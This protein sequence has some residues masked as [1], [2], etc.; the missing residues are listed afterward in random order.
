MKTIVELITPA[1]AEELL[2]MNTANRPANMVVVAAYADMMTRG[3]WRTNG[4]TITIGNGVLV[5]GQHRLLA[6]IR[7]GVSI[8]QNVSS[9]VDP[10]AYATVD[11]GYGRSPGQVL[12][13]MGIANA[14]TTAK[15]CRV[16]MDFEAGLF[17]VTSLSGN[18][19]R[20]GGSLEEVVAYYKR[21]E[22]EVSEGVTEGYAF[23]AQAKFLPASDWCIISVILRRTG[24]PALANEF[25]SQLATGSGLGDKDVLLMVRALFYN[26]AASTMRLPIMHKYNYVFRAW[27]RVRQGRR[28]GMVKIVKE[29]D[30]P[31][32]L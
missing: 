17:S 6:V 20:I 16:L 23:H 13:T 22:Q 3:L 19:K 5:D 14:N 11:R 9:E 12:A 21:H 27:N 28:E 7:S 30:F 29:S 15:V 24:H 26:A 31:T 25:L 32:P 8:T 10:D 1:R 4:T 2:R 18:A